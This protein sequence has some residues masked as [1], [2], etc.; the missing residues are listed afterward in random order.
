MD[1]RVNDLKA[2]MRGAMKNFSSV[3]ETTTP[4]V[5]VKLDEKELETTESV[6]L[7]DSV[8]L[9][10]EQIKNELN[11]LSKSLQIY[12][13]SGASQKHI[14]KLEEQ[15]TAAKDLPITTALLQGNQVAKDIKAASKGRGGRAK[16]TASALEVMACWKKVMSAE[17]TSPHATD[18]AI[19]A[20]QF[21]DGQKME[22]VEDQHTIDQ[23]M[24]QSSS[25]VLTDN[26]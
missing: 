3:F 23:N 1:T 22:V 10:T 13:R 26:A 9:E 7:V 11:V 15:L 16:I 4:A 19:A 25:I 5:L 6:N 8:D 21:S 17:L 14:E 24:E 2:V 20:A 18:A 12:F